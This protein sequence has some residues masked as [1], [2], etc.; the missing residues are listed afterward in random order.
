[1][2]TQTL[3]LQNKRVP[4]LLKDKNYEVHDKAWKAEMVQLAKMHFI[5][6]LSDA[7]A[8]AATLVPPSV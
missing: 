8:W 4:F 2:D 1:M 6:R 7:R 3:C 5:S